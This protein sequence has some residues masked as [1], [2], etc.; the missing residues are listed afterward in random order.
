MVK[1]NLP[2]SGRTHVSLPVSLT[3]DVIDYIDRRIE[4]LRPQVA[5]RAHYFRLLIEAEKTG[6]LEVFPKENDQ[7][8]LAV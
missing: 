2:K 1:A 5:S 8:L 3:Q 6:Q 7:L 4:E